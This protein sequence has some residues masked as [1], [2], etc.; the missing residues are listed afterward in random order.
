MTMGMFHASPPWQRAA[1]LVAS[2][3]LIA[4]SE[5]AKSTCPAMN[6]LRP[7]PEPLGV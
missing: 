3:V 4:E 1:A 2:S 7:V 6:C 5:P